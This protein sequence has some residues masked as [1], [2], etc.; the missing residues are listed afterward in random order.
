MELNKSIVF[1]LNDLN[2]EYRTLHESDVTKEYLDSL[3]KQTENI[4]NIPD[5][6]SISTQQQYIKEILL[7]NSDTINGLFISNKLVGTAGIQSSVKFLKNVDLPAE[8]IVSIGIF[9]F[10]M[11]YRGL[12][13]GSTLV[14]AS[15]HLFHDYTGEEWFSAGMKKENIPSL[16]SFLSCGFKQVYEDEEYYKVLLN[17]SELTKPEFIID[18]AIC[19]VDE[20]ARSKVVKKLT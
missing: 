5:N 3:S 1:K 2:C 7:S 4:E 20:L 8:S 17:Y 14:W 10:D 16:K 9:L 6:S 12:G 11:N 19:G 15:V 18:K 13:L